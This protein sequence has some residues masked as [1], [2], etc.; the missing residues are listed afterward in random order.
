MADN[1]F[2]V[3]IE[4]IEELLAR[5]KDVHMTP[6]E[7]EEQRRSWAFGNT[8]LSNPAVTREIVDEATEKIGPRRRD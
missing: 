1:K 3:K 4:G 6:E 7:E 8:A 2:A 5:A